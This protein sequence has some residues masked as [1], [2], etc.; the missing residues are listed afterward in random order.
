MINTQDC[1]AYP[2]AILLIIIYI[3][4]YNYDDDDDDGDDDDDDN[5][6]LG[7]YDLD[8]DQYSRLPRLPSCC[9]PHHHND[10]EDLVGLNLRSNNRAF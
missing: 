10:N 7:D 2:P 5:S 4:N 1:H 9:S 3:I 8:D 6:G